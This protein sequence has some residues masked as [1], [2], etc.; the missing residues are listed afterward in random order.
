MFTQAGIAKAY[1]KYDGKKLKYYMFSEELPPLL[2][3]G[4]KR[5]GLIMNI[6]REELG[7]YIED[8]VEKISVKPLATPA[9]LV[10][11]ATSI[12][13]TPS[14]DLLHALITRTPRPLVELLFELIDI[15]NGY[16]KSRPLIPPKKLY[17]TSRILIRI[18][19]LLGYPVM[20][21]NTT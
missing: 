18:L 9:V 3:V 20:E 17:I 14:R 8:G 4:G 12:A 10:W 15:G 13:S 5:A 16:R 1:V 19:E 21:A 6:L 11:I 7:S 2:V